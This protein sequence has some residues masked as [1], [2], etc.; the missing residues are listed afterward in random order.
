MRLTLASLALALAFAEAWPGR[1]CAADDWAQV[2]PPVAF[3]PANY[4]GAIGSF[5][6]SMRAQPTEL[7]AEDPLV[8]TVRISG[9][10]N[11]RDLKRPNLRKFRAFVEAFDIVDL[12]DRCLAEE[13]V[14]E[15]DYRL[16]PRNGD[17]R[18]IPHLNFV[19]FKPGIIP[20]EKG[21][22]VTYAPPLAIRV[23]P[24][25][26]LAPEQIKGGTDIRWP[27]SVRH[28]MSGSGVL[29]TQAT[30]P[31]PSMPLLVAWLLAPPL[32]CTFWCIAGNRRQNSRRRLRLSVHA[33]KALQ[34]LDQCVGANGWVECGRI[35]SDYLQQVLGPL[36]SEVSP[37]DLSARLR[38]RGTSA[39]VACEAAQ[40]LELR[41]AA[42]FAPGA[43][44]FHP[45][46]KEK[47]A[48]L[49]T[50]LEK[51]AWD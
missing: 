19:Y 43:P 25:P 17:I 36:P 50:A 6:I 40:L 47:A 13:A 39:D 5:K 9:R 4:D 24:R 22:Q 20:P 42:R 37:G 41:E 2:V 27:Q 8:L 23:L 26:E 15:F 1:G 12:G 28:Y 46:F 7:L 48:L 18:E 10:G 31:F 3:R 33:R 14:R 38:E 16:R 21:Y 30:T 44:S 45:S 11:L 29:Q 35:M 51:Q 34:K 49:I 32:V